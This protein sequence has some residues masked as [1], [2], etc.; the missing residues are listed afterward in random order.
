M[1]LTR[2]AVN[3]STSRDWKMAGIPRILTILVLSSR[4]TVRD[5]T[6]WNIIGEVKPD[7]LSTGLMVMIGRLSGSAMR[8]DK[9][10][11]DHR[12]WT[13]SHK[14]KVGCSWALADRLTLSD[15]K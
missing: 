3:Y 7:S 5:Q 10:I 13:N 15:A 14:E 2:H 6:L 8:G 4:L 12:S 11:C 1:E 9:E